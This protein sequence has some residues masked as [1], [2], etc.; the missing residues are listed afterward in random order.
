MRAIGL[1][2]FSKGWVAVVIDGDD[3]AI[4]FHA[5]VADALGDPFGRAGIDSGTVV[6]V[7]TLFGPAQVAARLTELAFGRNIHPLLIARAA[8]A[9]LVLAFAL[10]ALSGISVPVAAALL[11]DKQRPALLEATEKDYA[12]L[13]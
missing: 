1:D 4:S 6:F 3:R 11:D 10:L 8:V 9:L 7:G 13:R 2:G 12:A 5:D